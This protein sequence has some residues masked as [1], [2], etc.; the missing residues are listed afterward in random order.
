MTEEVKS[1][2]FQRFYRADPAR[3]SGQGT[4]LGLAI[5]QEIVEIHNASIE[6]QSVPGQG[7][8]IMVR[9]PPAPDM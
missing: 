8:A 1:K 7:T 2:L 3:T 6:V 4:G 9:F 5:A